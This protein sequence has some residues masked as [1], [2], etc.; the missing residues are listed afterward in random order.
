M[1]RYK[2]IKV[3]RAERS[4]SLN[5]KKYK[6]YYLKLVRGCD[7]SADDLVRH[8]RE[9]YRVDEPTTIKVMKAL[10]ETIVDMILVGRAVDLPFIGKITPSLDVE[11]VRQ[12]KD[13]NIRSIKGI[14]LRFYPLAGIK[15]AL[16]KA[17]YQIRAT[18]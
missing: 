12:E 18:Q 10:E 16:R 15:R 17:K 11:S 5:G 8:I 9:N 3:E 2:H 7:L 13:L 14:K 4:S 1:R 6:T